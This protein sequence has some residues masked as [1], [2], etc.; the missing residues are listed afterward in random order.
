MSEGGRT[1]G[2]HAL[3]AGG[4]WTLTK[5]AEDPQGI[6]SVFLSFSAEPVQVGGHSREGCED[7]WTKR[8]GP[9]ALRGKVRVGEMEH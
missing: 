1:C 4:L 7:A 6:Q 3:R 5:A 9:K 8:L 2:A